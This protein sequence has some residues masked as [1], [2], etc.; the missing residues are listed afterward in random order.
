VSRV[1]GFKEFDGGKIGWLRE[2]QK[3]F[4]AAIGGPTFIESDSPPADAFLRGG[5]VISKKNSELYEIQGFN[6]AFS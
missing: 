3:V 1:C 2:N 5:L 4:S 6:W